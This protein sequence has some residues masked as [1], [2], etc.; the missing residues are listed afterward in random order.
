MTDKISIPLIAKDMLTNVKTARRIVENGGKEFAYDL[1][2]SLMSA[3]YND[4]YSI[5]QSYTREDIENNIGHK[6]TEKEFEDLH[7]A[8][9]CFENIRI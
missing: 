7:S 9:V 4:G 2:V 8:L 5:F 6:P 1:A 3:L